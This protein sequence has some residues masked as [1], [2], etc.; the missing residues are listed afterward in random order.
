ML[1]GWKDFLT[2]ERSILPVVT[3]EDD[4]KSRLLLFSFSSLAT[5]VRWIKGEEATTDML[6]DVDT[7]N[8]I[9]YWGGGNDDEIRLAIWV[10]QVVLVSLYEVCWVIYL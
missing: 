5:S 2:R 4:S 10:A 9:E 8:E 1:G 3:G 6:L 7:G